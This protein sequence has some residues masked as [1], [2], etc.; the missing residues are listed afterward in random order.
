MLLEVNL[1]ARMESATI[2]QIHRVKQLQINSVD[3]L[4]VIRKLTRDQ[5]LTRTYAFKE[6]RFEPPYASRRRDRKKKKTLPPIPELMMPKRHNSF[7]EEL[8]EELDQVSEIPTLPSITISPAF[9]TERVDD[10]S[11]SVEVTRKSPQGHL[12]NAREFTFPESGP[13][14][15]RQLP[16][17]PQPIVPALT[18]R[19]R[20]TPL[21]AKIEKL[22]KQKRKERAKRLA[23]RRY[24]RKQHNMTDFPDTTTHMA[25]RPRREPETQ[26][27]FQL[28]EQKQSPFKQMVRAQEETH[29]EK[30]RLHP[31][32]YNRIVDSIYTYTKGIQ[33]AGWETEH[34]GPYERLM[35]TP[36][37]AKEETK[38]DI[39]RHVAHSP[40]FV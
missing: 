9:I 22:A 2:E 27:T 15:K 37:T 1:A 33:D 19:A 40:H 20:D 12:F 14:R 30:P 4:P 7:D 18:P 26:T 13:H 5:G 16:G 25:F 38:D 17:N 28:R 21:Q 35:V 10:R 29:A 32:L 6:F 3:R 24:E 36:V 11:L 8:D 23:E 34:Q 39:H 31:R